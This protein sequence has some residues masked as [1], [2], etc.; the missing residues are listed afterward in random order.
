[1]EFEYVAEV[2]QVSGVDVEDGHRPPNRYT[3]TALSSPA[4]LVEKVIPEF[5]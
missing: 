1:M 2:I 4:P 3:L 5:K